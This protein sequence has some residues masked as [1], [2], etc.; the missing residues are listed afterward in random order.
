MALVRAAVQTVIGTG[1]IVLAVGKGG[2]HRQDAID[3][4][5]R[6]LETS[7]MFVIF[8]HVTSMEIGSVEALGMLHCRRHRRCPT[9]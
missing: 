6:L 2:Y 1:E 9:P 8:P 3:P 4:D 7:E 5:H